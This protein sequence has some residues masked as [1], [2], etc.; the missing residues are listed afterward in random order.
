MISVPIHILNQIFEDFFFS[1]GHF[2]HIVSILSSVIL[3]N[4]LGLL[5]F[6]EC[7]ISFF[8]TSQLRNLVSWISKC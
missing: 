1:L 6:V 3:E 5:S 8:I 7:E 4:K 2:E